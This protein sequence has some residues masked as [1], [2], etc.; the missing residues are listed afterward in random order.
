MHVTYVRKLVR[1]EL[2]SKVKKGHELLNYDLSR[3]TM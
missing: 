2:P 1:I 3:L